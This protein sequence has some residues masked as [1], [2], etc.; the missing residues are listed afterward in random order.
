M[1]GNRETVPT[2]RDSLFSLDSMDPVSDP[3]NDR[4]VAQGTTV[5]F[6]GEMSSD[7]LG[8]VNYT[9][10]FKYNDTY[11]ISNNVRH[12]FFFDIPGI[13]NISLI[14]S[15]RAARTDTGYMTVTVLDT[16]PP[17]VNA[18]INGNYISDHST[19]KVEAEKSNE[20][21]AG[22]SR[23]NIGIENYTW[24]IELDDDGKTVPPI[25]LSGKTVEYIF[26]ESGKYT[27]T[28]TV[29]DNAR[30]TDEITFNVD[31]SPGASGTTD[32]NKE[33][34]SSLCGVLFIG[35]IV[36]L[37]FAV[38]LFL[39]VMAKRKKNKDSE[40]LKGDPRSGG[41]RYRDVD[42]GDYLPLT[43]KEV[44]EEELQYECSI[45]GGLVDGGSNTCPHCH[46]EFEEELE[47]AEYVEEIMDD[48]KYVV[49]EEAEEV[50]VSTKENRKLA[51]HLRKRIFELS[52]AIEQ[53]KELDIS[54]EDEA[55]ALKVIIKL[56]KIGKFSDAIRTIKGI[57][58][59]IDEKLRNHEKQHHY[60]VIGDAETGLRELEKEMG[61]HFAG[62][63]FYLFSARQSVKLEEYDVVDD[64]LEKFYKE[65]ESELQDTENEIG[66][67]FKD[68][69]FYLFSAKGSVEG[70]EYEEA[71]EYLDLFFEEKEM[72]EHEV[73]KKSKESKRL[74]RSRK[75]QRALPSKTKSSGADE[76]WDDDSDK[77][78]INGSKRKRKR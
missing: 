27:I 57:K 50:P 4:T 24:V 12:S 17:V 69:H 43:Y 33:T 44:Y 23:D 5:S 22:G 55:D 70:E 2:E 37:T 36:V 9:W 53:A 6:N 14:V 11:H 35:L 49:Y 1:A 41:G 16:I 45:C 67:H 10:I 30:N 66:D 40:N 64:Y 21:N 29:Y 61:E 63:H 73:V 75:K 28:L 19:F 25:T 26:D 8:I 7:N 13:Y 18:S 46:A 77:K 15:D 34:L 54:V 31:V 60:D 32:E 51:K 68:L 20:F 52:A 74:S 58:A 62:L 39:F 78:R 59:S 72:V 76:D 47:E 48:S 3:G 56:K 42:D 65:K 71:D 38:I